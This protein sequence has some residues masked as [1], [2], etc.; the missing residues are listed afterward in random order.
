MYLVDAHHLI[1]DRVFDGDDVDV[2][3][4]DLCQHGVERGGFAGAGGTGHQHH[5]VRGINGAFEFGEV[6]GF[7]AERI[8]VGVEAAFIEHA[9]D[10]FFAVDGG[11]NGNAQVHVAPG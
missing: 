1:F 4:I 2:G 9:H 7:H 5:A 8:E 3:S 11:Q 6:V 10:D